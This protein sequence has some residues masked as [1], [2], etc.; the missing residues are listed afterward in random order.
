MFSALGAAYLAGL[1]AGIFKDLE[2]LER[3]DRSQRDY[4]PGKKNEQ[5]LGYYEEWK[6]CL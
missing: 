2:A 5:I 3:L 6:S 1:Q 4:S